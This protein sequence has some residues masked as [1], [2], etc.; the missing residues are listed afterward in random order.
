MVKSEKKEETKQEKEH[1]SKEGKGVTW[2]TE[3]VLKGLSNVFPGL[4]GLI[5]GLEKSEA[6]QERLKEIDE[7]IDKKVRETPLKETA[8]T[9]T[10][11]FKGGF[12]AR[13]SV[14]K[15]KK[16]LRDIPVDIFDEEK[17]IDIVAELP[18][19]EEK[20]IKVDLSADILAISADAAKF[21]YSKKI[22]LPCKPKGIIK[23]LYK[24]GIME[25]KLA[26]EK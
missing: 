1:A 19:I 16:V 12:E 25:I 9:E 14:T 4:G 21:R 13:P 6:F 26:K 23:K 10:S 18:G 2:V 5:K 15:G 22:Q 3:R 24:N 20:D 7:E 17:Y 8:V 11:W